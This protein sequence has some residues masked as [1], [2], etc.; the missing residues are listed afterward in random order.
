M[1]WERYIDETLAQGAPE[2]S[3]PVG[4]P[5]FD[6]DVEQAPAP[7]A[8]S[9]PLNP[10]ALLG[11][12]DHAGPSANNTPTT[13]D[14]NAP[15]RLPL[16]RPTIG[17]EEQLAA[18][19]AKRQAEQ[20]LIAPKEGTDGITNV[21]GQ[22]AQ[23]MDLLVQIPEEQRGKMIDGLDEKAFQALMT[24]VPESERERFS[25]LV[26]SS[27]NPKRKLRMWR[28]FHDAK[29]NN[30]LHRYEH[31]DR[32]PASGPD[33]TE[34]ERNVQRY[35]SRVAGA[36]QTRTEVDEEM[37][38]LAAK[39]KAGTLTI[40][41]ID[42]MRGRKDL[43]LKVELEHNVN[44]TAQK[45]LREN[46]ERVTWAKDELQ[47]VDAALDQLPEEATRD[48]KTLPQIMRTAPTDFMDTRSGQYW[49]GDKIEIVD[50]AN[51]AEK[52]RTGGQREM[53][54]NRLRNDHG[55]TVGAL[56]YTV[57]HEIGHD[58][59][60]H[61]AKAFKKF[62]EA[63]GWKE[64]S[65]ADVAKTGLTARQQENLDNRRRHALGE[66]DLP[67]GTDIE[68]NG[69]IYT[70][71]G[72]DLKYKGHY[73]QVDGTAI[74]SKDETGTDRW[75]YG[76]RNPTEHFAEVYAKAVH[77]P[78]TLYKDL[79]DDPTKAATTARGKVAEQKRAIAALKKH[80]TADSQ[81]KIAALERQMAQLE[82]AAKTAETA[83][84]QRGDQFSIMRNDVFHTD[85][86]V[87]KS[88]KRLRERKYS[89]AQIL[90]FQQ[91]A[92]RASTPAQIAKLEGELER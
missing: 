83:Q 17:T 62:K 75:T 23:A 26:D 18:I 40:A 1:F 30:D 36:K 42:E 8:P 71:Y 53:V 79:V 88:I 33:T 69:K 31:L 63:A 67:S 68:A 41:D 35:D 87:E 48:S 78:E 50:N 82:T 45:Q 20:L 49:A 7:V 51:K 86:A 4:A 72:D 3:R 6:D 28:Q 38:L 37:A 59:E 9:G 60:R 27:Q 76:K 34:Q 14:P 21:G 58:A 61:H 90:K 16:P 80:P 73:W 77:M 66:G 10:A 43:E 46:G 74:P 81:A 56:E 44:L 54:S 52:D 47:Q 24:N 91:Q 57:T 89:E 2:N 65:G 39:E 25:A 12:I 32:G 15:A 29:L 22:A 84:K 5:A 13:L 19:A 11:W 92:A 85:D 55:D 64:V 70:P